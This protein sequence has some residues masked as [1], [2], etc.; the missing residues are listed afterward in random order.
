MGVRDRDP[1]TGPHESIVDTHGKQKDRNEG[2]H[3]EE[4]LENHQFHVYYLQQS[5]KTTNELTIMID[6]KEDIEKI[7]KSA[8]V[9]LPLIILL[10]YTQ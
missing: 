7:H 4:T 8:V 5:I 10:R 9:P 3:G 6:V 1:V 2:P